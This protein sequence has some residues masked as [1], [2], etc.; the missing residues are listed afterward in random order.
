MMLTLHDPQQARAYYLDGTW[1]QDTLYTLLSQHANNRPSCVA[2]RDPYS[3]LAWAEVLA[4]VDRVAAS[5]HRA[6]LVRGDRVAIWLP[7]RIE[8]AIIF[9]ACSRNGYVCCPSLHQSYTAGEVVTLLNRIRC[10]AFSPRPITVPMP[11]PTLSTI[12]SARF[13]LSN[14]FTP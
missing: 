14:R 11:S 6:G 2:L 3:R 9:L 10:K 8:C 5:L 4:Q 7:N 12:T 1:Q 13:R